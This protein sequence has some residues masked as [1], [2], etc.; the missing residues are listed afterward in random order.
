MLLQKATPEFSSFYVEEPRLVF[1]GGQTAVDPKVGISSFGPIGSDPNLIA[2]EYQSWSSWHRRRN[3]ES[4][5][6]FR[7]N[8]RKS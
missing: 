1:A 5:D 8:A 2:E 6:V 3:S 4:T 7:A